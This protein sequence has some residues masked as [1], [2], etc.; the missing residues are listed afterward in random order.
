MKNNYPHSFLIYSLCLLL[1]CCSSDRIKDKDNLSEKTITWEQIEK[2]TTQLRA[3]DILTSEI[4]AGIRH[5][6]IYDD[7]LLISEL[8]SSDSTL[9][10]VDLA[11][12]EVR[13]NLIKSGDGPFELNL[14]DRVDVFDNRISFYE[15]YQNKLYVKELSVDGD[16]EWDHN[17]ISYYDFSTVFNHSAFMV[18]H[19][20]LAM[21]Y[22]SE[23]EITRFIELDQSGNLIKYFGDYPGGPDEVKIYENFIG[24]AYKANVNIRR[25]GKRFAL[26]YGNQDLI[27]IYDLNAQLIHSVPGPDFFI[28]YFKMNEKKNGLGSIRDKTKKAY[29]SIKSGQEEIWALYSGKLTRNSNDPDAD[30]NVCSSIIVLDWDGNFLRSY[31]LSKPIYNMAIDLKEIKNSR[32]HQ[33]RR[34]SLGVFQFR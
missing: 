13:G 14:V 3:K 23:G 18:N 10:M 19:R 33:S 30:S 8:E 25:D 34:Q 27:E 12:M 15:P 24:V 7:N 16:L 4:F 6:K 28:P 5:L 1:V 29:L 17:Q 26:A 22:L 2:R 32:C 21:P 11:S 9:K 20:L 31:S